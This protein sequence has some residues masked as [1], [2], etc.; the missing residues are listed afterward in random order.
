MKSLMASIIVLITLVGCASSSKM[1]EDSYLDHTLKIADA[2]FLEGNGP[3]K[4]TFDENGRWLTIETSATAPLSF[5]APEG[6]EIAFKMA[7]MRAKRNLAE[8]LSNDL[9]SSKSS[10]NLK[11]V[12]EEHWPDTKQ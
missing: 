8:F 12:S 4:L 7:T 1:A 11:V 2:E 5:D 3:L 10:D 9:K 6:R